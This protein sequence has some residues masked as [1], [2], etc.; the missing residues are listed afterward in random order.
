MY[1]ILGA[2]GHI[3]S[4]L[5]ELLLE[6]GLPVTVVTRNAGSVEHWKEKG[7]QVAAL[8][9]HDVRALRATFERGRRA[10][11]LNPPAP[12]SSDTDREERATVRAILDALQGS[13]L[14]KVVA[15]ST[16]GAQPGAAIGDLGVL[17]EFE[18]GLAQ[19]QLPAAVIRGAYYMS[20]WDMSLDTARG[21]G[22][23]DSFFPAAFRLPMVA[24]RDIAKVAAQFL[25]D[26]TTGLHHVEGPSHYCSADVAAAFAKALNHPV[27]VRV[28]PP[29]QFS[30]IL[31]QA[32]FSEP[33]AR[34]M[35]AMTQ[36]VLEQP[37]EAEHPLRGETTLEQY[38][39]RLVGKAPAKLA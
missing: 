27:K 33:A 17:Y 11:L 9:V 32:G 6:R 18:Q 13:G 20:N 35:A 15:Q 2:T 19:L 31:K 24:P 25:T 36:T 34:S 30:T 10:Y 21:E 12:P 8:D 28:A 4:A 16:Y 23:I 29:D 3:G 39:A 14:E 38:I 26:E 5:T 37:F 1:I 22:V 7:A